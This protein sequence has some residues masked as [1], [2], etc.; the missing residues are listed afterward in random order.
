MGARP[1][2][3]RAL[4]ALAGVFL[5]ELGCGALGCSAPAHWSDARTD[6]DRVPLSVWVSASGELFTVGGPLGS[7]GDTLFL[8]HDAS[9]WHEEAVG[10]TVTLWWVFGFGP[11][12]VWTVGEEGTVLHWDGA[13]LTPE[14]VPTTE[15][16]F[17]I[18]GSSDDDLWAV[19]GKPDSDGVILHRVAGNWELVAIARNTG[20]FFKVW[21]AAADDAWVCGQGGTVLHWDGAGLTAEPTSLPPNVSLFTVSGRSASDVYAVGGLGNAAAVHRDPAAGTA[22]G[23]WSA[24]EDPVLKEAEALAGVS[25]APN[26]T[27][28][29]V[30][31]DGTRLVGKPGH[32]QDDSDPAAGADFHSV[33]FNPDGPHENEAWAVGGNW[34]APAPAMRT[35]TIVHYGP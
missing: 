20:A 26:G 14:S 22:T 30:G 13:T 10:S 19:G 34:Q 21:G 28:A 17:G 27:V 2:L 18:W 12:D 33:A 15:T 23:S 4:L 6:L 8:R 35:G 5:L 29:M 32:L 25:V 31:A 24:V 16:L 9:G 11:S 1:R 7:A 3:A